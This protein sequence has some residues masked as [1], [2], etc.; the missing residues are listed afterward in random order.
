MI[1]RFIRNDR[2]SGLFLAFVAVV[3]LYRV[4]S[5]L[6]PHLV[7]FYDEAQYYH[8]SMNPDWGYYSKPPMVA[9]FIAMTTGL[10]GSSPFAIKLASPILYSL[11]TLVLL[12]T[13]RQLMDERAALM[14]A[15]IFFTS[16]LVGYNSLFI[17]TDA[18]LILFWC[19][20]LWAFV[21][22]YK[23]NRLRDWILVGTFCGLGML[24]KYTMAALPGSLF[25]F[26]LLHPER[27]QRLLTVGPWFAAVLAGVI[28][29]ANLIWNW[30][31][32]FV[33]FRHTSEISGVGGGIFPIRLLE[34]L[35]AQ[36]LVFGPVWM[37]LLLR[38]GVA[39]W[40]QFFTGEQALLHFISL[41]LLAVISVQALLS[42]AYINWAAPAYVGASLL[43]AIWLADRQRLLLWGGMANLLLLALI[44]HWPIL[45]DAAGIQRSK[46]SDPWFRVLGYDQVGYQ[47]ADE[48]QNEP[49]LLL[50]S[51]SR[52]LLA[53][54]GYYASPDELRLASWQPDP[55]YVADYYDQEFNLRTRQGDADQSYLLIMQQP[56]EGAMLERFDRAEFVEKLDIPVYHNLSREIWV[57]RLQGFNGYAGVRESATSVD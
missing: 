54:V 37:Y 24:S 19:L 34:F 2:S 46:A 40:R 33:A 44:S 28:F 14:A 55:D 49:G 35:V 3:T 4:T 26:L 7:L 8:W 16:T 22:A 13:A 15:W 29:S 10:L 50:L 56:A 48:L 25:L 47:L 51:P 38:Q 41:P 18:P 42:H 53:A 31:N 21:L 52:K 30:Q 32:G 6:Q 1:S 9:W 12:A 39:R 27:R 45:A 5:L 23:Q 20:T 57:Y 17:T 36:F 11:S 43:L